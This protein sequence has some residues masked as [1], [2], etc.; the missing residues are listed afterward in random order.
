MSK[1]THQAIKKKY[2]D[3][4]SVGSRTKQIVHLVA[5]HDKAA[6]LEQI[7]K[8]SDPQQTVIITKSKRKAD[9][10]RTYLQT[11]E[12]QAFAIHGNHR[13]LE[14]EATRVAF[15]TSEI[16]ILIT[17]DKILQSLLLSNIQ[18]IIS[19]DLPIQADD[20]FT[21]LAYVDEIGEVISL[22]SPDEQGTLNI[23]EIKM[24]LDIPQEEIKEFL[25]TPLTAADET[26][27]A[28]KDKK[29][30]PRHRTQKVKKASKPKKQ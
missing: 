24:K 7:I 23:I 20:Y 25:P 8:K 15:N 4:V 10:L 2:Y 19:Y 16:N 29:K 11:K 18:Q 1:Q 13:A 14:Y 30:K 5:Q 17:T 3:Y 28:P 21:R 22:V 6:M 12:I 26:P 9:A 27:Q